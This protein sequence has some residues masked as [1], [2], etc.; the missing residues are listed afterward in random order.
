MMDFKKKPGLMLLI[1]K[2]GESMHEPMESDYEDSPGV[3]D[4]HN[5]G[6]HAA[7]QEMMEA[8]KGDNVAS[9]V[10]ALENFV[11]MCKKGP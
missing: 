1:K 9:F 5:E 6:K 2:M 8:I 4:F 3:M 11:R 7:A 10:M